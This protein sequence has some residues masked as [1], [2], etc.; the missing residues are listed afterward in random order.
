MSR[1]TLTAMQRDSRNGERARFVVRSLNGA[2]TLVLLLLLG[3]MANPSGAGDEGLA[4]AGGDTFVPFVRAAY[5]YDSNLFRLQNDEAADAVLGGRSRAES[6]HT[7]AAGMDATFRI[8]R[9]AV[10]AHAEYNRT[11]FNRYSRLNHDG[12]DAYLKWDWLLGSV[13]SGNVG[14]AETL[15]QASYAHVR[16]PVS[17]LIRTR[18]YFAHAAVGLDDP[19]LVKFG[20][21]RIDRN[22]EASLLDEQDATVDA[23]SA[24][25]QLRSRKGSTLELISERRDG[26]YPNRQAVGPRPIANDY[27]QSD[28]GVAVVWLPAGNTK[29]SARLNYTERSHEEVPQRD[30]SGLT[31]FLGADWRVTGKTT[32]SA[33]AHREI[34]AIEND[35]ATYTL[36]EGVVLGADWKSTDKLAFNARFRHDEIAYAG[37]PGFVLAWSPSREDRLT[38]MQAGAEYSVSENV[39][40]GAALKRGVRDSSED[41]AS[42][43]YNSALLSVRGDF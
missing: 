35:T 27:V 6:H 38:T 8:N 29:L 43:A 30:F 15:A 26:R 16:Q 25:V 5:G 23:V 18:R 33:S 11:W 3:A 13:V 36:N 39:T 40:L 9:Q 21:E 28:N 22:H 37:D 41:L 20:A 4:E 24:G 31:G 14:V 1:R 2:E 32:L 19:W 12:R 7:L 10:L 34:G 17:N 42:Y